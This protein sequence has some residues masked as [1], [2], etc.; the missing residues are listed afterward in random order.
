[1]GWEEANNFPELLITHAA[2][3]Y[4]LSGGTSPIDE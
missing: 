2:L 3:L 4:A 1:V